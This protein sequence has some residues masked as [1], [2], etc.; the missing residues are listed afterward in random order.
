MLP[1]G[2]IDW[3][4]KFAVNGNETARVVHPWNGTR[5][6]HI[7]QKKDCLIGDSYRISLVAHNFEPFSEV[8]I[9]S[10]N[11]HWI[12]ICTRLNVTINL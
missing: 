9:D 3:K 8:A 6:P 2:V 12:V 10:F 11:K 7:K 1:A 5:V 4:G